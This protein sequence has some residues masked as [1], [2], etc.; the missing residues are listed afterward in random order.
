MQIQAQVFFVY[1]GQWGGMIVP[2]QQPP[3][4]NSEKESGQGS[5]AVRSSFKA[6]RHFSELEKG[7]LLSLIDLHRAVL[8]SRKGDAG[9]VLRKQ[10]TWQLLAQEFNAHPCVFQRDAKQLRK[11]WENIKAR[12]KKTAAQGRRAKLPIGERRP[13]GSTAKTDPLI[14]LE[15]QNSQNAKDKTGSSAGA[16]EQ[17]LSLENPEWKNLHQQGRKIVSVERQSGLVSGS[18]SSVRVPS[19]DKV[20]KASSSTINKAVPS[21]TSTTP[22]TPSAST[23]TV[24]KL[25]GSNRLA[26]VKVVDLCE[27]DWGSSVDDVISCSSS[28]KSTSSQSGATPPIPA[29]CLLLPSGPEKADLS[30]DGQERAGE[31]PRAVHGVSQPVSFNTS[32]I[33]PFSA[34][35]I[36]ET[37]GRL[38][39]AKD[40]RKRKANFRMLPDNTNGVFMG[41]PRKEEQLQLA[42]VRLQ[43]RQMTELHTLKRQQLKRAMEMAE[44]E[45][46]AK[47]KMLRQKELFWEKKI[48]TLVTAAPSFSSSSSSSSASSFCSQ[49]PHLAPAWKDNMNRFNK[50]PM[51]KRI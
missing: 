29:N 30:R 35:G 36:G 39:L 27:D 9:T 21:L 14:R 10:R 49:T 48:Q 3:Y 25:P 41:P 26:Q 16:N 50:E 23:S 6:S 11:C 38:G 37:D 20:R 28:T 5:S 7:V 18:I 42:M 1:A 8:E 45:H 24:Q 19:L 12:A 32:S 43:I 33:S 47:I 15:T 31:N 17:G 44:E 4:W 22:V 40:K 2:N 51:D 13:L 46:K 34:S